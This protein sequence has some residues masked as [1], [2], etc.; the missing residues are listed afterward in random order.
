MSSPAASTLTSKVS[1]NPG[2]T[3][4]LEADT[5]KK[6]TS[7]LYSISRPLPTSVSSLTNTPALEPDW[8]D[9]DDAS[10]YGDN[11]EVQ[12]IYISSDSIFYRPPATP[13]TSSYVNISGFPFACDALKEEDPFL[14]ELAFDELNSGSGDDNVVVIVDTDST[15]DSDSQSNTG[16]KFTE[17][18][19]ETKSTRTDIDNEAIRLI[20]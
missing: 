12:Y 7:N 13:P 2:L 14:A 1:K 17:K 20:S 5:S 4:D 3:I 11:A 19:G 10:D 9:E 15:E 16:W 18:L 8:I 6:L